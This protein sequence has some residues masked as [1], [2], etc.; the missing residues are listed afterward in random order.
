ML[1]VFAQQLDA[2]IEIAAWNAQA[3]RFFATRLGLAAAQAHAPATPAPR[4]ATTS[5][6]IAPD[7]C[8][9]G[10]RSLSARPRDPRDL[11]QADEAEARAAP[12][13]ESLATPHAPP[14]PHGM[15]RD[16]RS[17]SRPPHALRLAAILASLLLGPILDPSG[18]EIFGVK[19]AR[20]YLEAM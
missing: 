6:V 20:A 2:R 11:A 10:I 18:P 1:L 8:A 14:L 19:T 7:G 4:T 16:A 17:Q 15:A 9:P 13:A 12:E 3:T 5:L